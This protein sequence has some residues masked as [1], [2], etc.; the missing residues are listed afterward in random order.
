MIRLEK[1]MA[2]I[3]KYTDCTFK[4]YLRHLRPIYEDEKD[5]FNEIKSTMREPTELIVPS[6]PFT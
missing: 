2:E 5:D 6:L 3:K 1:I 4:E